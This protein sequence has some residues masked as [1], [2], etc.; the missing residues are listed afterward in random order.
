M[1]KHLFS[2]LGL[3][4]MM[5]VWGG[6][7]KADAT[8]TKV[9]EVNFNSDTD[10]QIP[11]GWTVYNEGYTR[12]SGTSWS[13]WA[14]NG[15][16][17]TYASG[18]RLFSFSSSVQSYKKALYIR[19][20]WESTKEAANEGYAYYGT[21][22]DY[23]LT[24]PAGNVEVRVPACLWTTDGSCKV[25]VALFKYDADKD[26]ADLTEVT[27]VTQTLAN[28]AGSSYSYN[29]SGME[30]VKLRFTN[31]TEGNF[32]I[33]VE[34][35][36]GAQGSTWTAIVFAGF[37]VY[38]YEG[39]IVESKYDDPTSVF[40]ETFAGVDADYTPAAGSGWT[41]YVSGK[42]KDKGIKSDWNNGGGARIKSISK[43]TGLTKIFYGNSGDYLI[44]GEA[45]D[46]EP[47]LELEAG[48]YFVSYYAA[49]WKGS[50]SQTLSILDE[51]G[52]E[53][54]SK[55]TKLTV[56]SNGDENKI[57]P[58]HIQFVVSIASK[59][60][61]QLKFSSTGEA[62]LGNISIRKNS[63][64]EAISENFSGVTTGKTY[65][66]VSYNGWKL[67]QDSDNMARFE[68]VTGG[69]DVTVTAYL[70]FNGAVTYGEE[71][72][73]PLTLVGGKEYRLSYYAATQDDL[74]TLSCNVY[75]DTDD[76]VS[77]ALSRVDALAGKVTAGVTG[78]PIV[79]PMDYIETTFTPSKSGN[80]ILKL[81]GYQVHVANVSIAENY[82]D[83]I[84]YQTKL[85]DAFGYS[86]LYVDQAAA[87]PEDV[88]VYTAALNDEGD[89][90]VLTQIKDNIP[91]G[92]GV[93]VKGTPGATATFKSATALPEE[94]ESNVLAGKLV[95]TALPTDATYYTL[96]YTDADD[97]STLGFYK[98]SAVAL[99][100]NKAYIAIS[101]SSS[102][103]SLRFD[104]DTDEPGNVTAIEQVKSEAAAGAI[105][106][107][108]GRRV[109]TMSK[110]GLYVVGGRK[111][112]V[113]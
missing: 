60:N 78:N 108:N 88:E 99:R 3:A 111:V 75:S 74:R 25:K 94:V 62:V 105:F 83:P 93:I 34:A 39:E 71:S 22:D 13:D 45:G 104:F 15:E 35:L 54:V 17:V 32:V 43:A 89:K 31:E 73:Y 51:N 100:A 101:G 77:V 50:V 48:D 91:A 107:L 5:L 87:I 52:G 53:V 106:D 49:G 58:N 7:A 33:K 14:D 28:S 23:P 68:S 63:D 40:E 98:S 86:T 80:Y 102:I 11:V 4:L 59:G 12:T 103:S 76:G 84:V 97:E 9:S 26:L 70:R 38:T 85:D 41:I 61:Y 42:A 18:P 20:Q 55:T 46:G 79:R 66:N 1:K 67:T 2:S 6:E 19:A 21:V 69:G 27:S 29:L 64:L 110:P 57:T 95:G 8:Y 112:L 65:A 10:N 30:N 82:A 72:S 56:N 47:S 81:T 109:A 16:K 90:V 37:S 36:A 96:A 113:K 44:Y 24:I 92:T